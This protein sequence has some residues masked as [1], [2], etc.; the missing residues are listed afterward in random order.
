LY[1]LIEQQLGAARLFTVGIG[2][3]P[4]S[5]FM[6][7]SAELGRG[8]FVII[9]A[10]HEVRE[11]MDRL[12]KKLESPQVTNIRVAWPGGTLIESYPD[13]VPDLYL[14]EPVTIRAKASGGFQAGDRVTISGDSASGAWTRD[15][16][17]VSEDD[18]PGIGALWARAKIAALHDDERR[19]ADAD[20]TRQ[21]IVDTALAH[22]LVS[23]HT[24]LVAVDKTPVRPAGD[25]LS[26]EQVANLMPYGQSMNAIF[27]FPA[28]ATDATLLRLRGLAAIFAAL[29]LLGVGR[30]RWGMNRARAA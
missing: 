28:T 1:A 19:G 18:A 24:S 9:S 22:H 7:K 27:G 2:S 10:L 11:K 6:R 4:N 16:L 21:S 13:V 29:L 3:A 15:L 25:P 12:F 17:L 14:G 30:T 20:I 5:W 23:K 8:T 26:K